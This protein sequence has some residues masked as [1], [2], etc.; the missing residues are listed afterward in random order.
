SDRAAGITAVVPRNT[1]SPT[2]STLLRPGTPPGSGTAGGGSTGGSGAVVVVVGSNGSADGSGGVGGGGGGG[3]GGA[4]V[5]VVDGTSAV[6]EGTVDGAVV[7]AEP[8]V[9]TPDSSSSGS[10]CGLAGAV[11]PSP[12]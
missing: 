2:T 5:V 10:G 6:V 7:G 1:E 8:V 12:V 11:G 3:G 9:G 4:L